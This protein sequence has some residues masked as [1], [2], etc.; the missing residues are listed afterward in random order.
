MFDS[1]QAGAFDYLLKP[2][3]DSRFVNAMDRAMAAL[4]RQAAGR[5]LIRQGN[6]CRIL[7]LDEILYCEVLGRKL[8]VHTKSGEIIDYYSRLEHLEQSVDSR[9]FRCHRSYLVNLDWVQGLTEGSALLP[10]GA[11]I[12]VS[13]LR[14]QTLTGKL[15]LRMKERRR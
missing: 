6:S 9:F 2:L 13:R 10:G 4:E 3:E 5:I 7:S 11:S 15:L 12:P 14:R 1:F 8:Y